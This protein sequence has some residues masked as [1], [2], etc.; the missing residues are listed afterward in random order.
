MANPGSGRNVSGILFADYVR[1]IRSQ[2]SIPWPREL[3]PEDHRHLQETIDLGGWYPMDAFER[4]GNLI[5]RH[6][7]L[8]DMSAVRLWGRFSVAAMY[9]ANPALVVPGDPLETVSRF[10]ALRAELFDFDALLI[11]MLRESEAHVVIGYRMGNPAE[12]AASEQTRGFFERLLE[13]AGAR[14]VQA[15]FSE[16]VWAGD[17]RT[18]LRLT[19][20]PPSRTSAAG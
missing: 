9:E 11:A 13:L 17:H 18:L 14:D 6:I 20:A 12:E 16:R 1:M 3:P 15:E 4:L 7:A 10:R 5:L 19:W 8:E 2:K